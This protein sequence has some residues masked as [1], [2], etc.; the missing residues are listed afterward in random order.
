MQYICSLALPFS[1]FISFFP[2]FLKYT[3]LVLFPIFPH[4]VSK[5]LTVHR[6]LTAWSLLNISNT[7]PVI[8][9]SVVFFLPAKKHK[10]SAHF[11][12]V[13]TV[14]VS[15]IIFILQFARG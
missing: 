1:L 9:L 14:R 10:H 2:H 3:L 6:K 5:V 7:Q 11:W 4:L 15:P 12:Q 8:R 13:F